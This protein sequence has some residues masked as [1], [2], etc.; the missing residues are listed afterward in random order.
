MKQLVAIIFIVF[1]LS[2]SLSAESKLEIVD[3]IFHFGQVPQN[4]IISNSFWFKSTGEDTLKITKI[5]TGCTCVMTPLVST[6]IAP[7]DSTLV[8]FHWDIGKRFSNIGNYPKILT[9]AQKKP[10]RIQL[11]ALAVRSMDAIE[12]LSCSPYIFELSG[13][14]DK[15]INEIEFELTNRTNMTIDL[16]IISYPMSECFIDFPKEIPPFSS[17]NGTIKVKPD[18]IDK[19]FN[20]S[21]T[22]SVTN[23]KKKM[24][25]I[26][27]RRKLY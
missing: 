18:Y 2:V 26:P 21:I 4:S 11:T 5:N 20:E 19:E 13:Y 3:N 8:S 12:P 15:K 7:G 16:E 10:Y 22:I 23:M 1:L 9:N 25:T 17:V 24:I 27:V 6:E 14:K